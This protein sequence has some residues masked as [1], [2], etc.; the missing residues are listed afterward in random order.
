MSFIQTGIKIWQSTPLKSYLSEA[1]VKIPS[2][3]NYKANLLTSWKNNTDQIQHITNV[4][5]RLTGYEHVEQRRMNVSVK[6]KILMKTKTESQRCKLAY[7]ESI[8]Y[9]RKCQKDL[10]LLLQ[11]TKV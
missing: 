1:M 2:F 11:V 9:R 5:N 4:F 7:E 6:D 3:Q 10:N 8:E